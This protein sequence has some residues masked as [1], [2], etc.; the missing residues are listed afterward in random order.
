[1]DRN[2][3]TEDNYLPCSR[4]ENYEPETD[5]FVKFDDHG[6]GQWY[7]AVYAQGK[8]L[9]RSEGYTNEP[10]RDNGVESVKS[11]M[12]SDNNYQAL[13]QSD[14]KWILS[15]R[16][17]NHK[18]I[19]RSC[20]F[21]SEAEVLA[22]L[23][24]ARRAALKNSDNRHEDDYLGCKE[25][26]GK[27][28]STVHPSFGA[29][30][31]EGH[32]FFVQYDQDGKVFLR[33]ERY[34]TPTARDNGINS[35]ISHMEDDKN[36][37][38]EEK[39]DHYFLVLKASNHQEIARSCPYESR[40]IALAMLPSA[41][42]AQ[43]MEPRHRT[44]DYLTCSEYEGHQQSATHPEVVQ[45]EKDGNYYFGFIDKNEG[46]VLMRSE[47]YSTPEACEKGINSVIQNKSIK[48]RFEVE[49]HAG[50]YFLILHAANN[51][52]IARS[53]PL[54]SEAAALALIGLMAGAP[55]EAKEEEIAESGGAGFKWWI[56]ALLL[57]V[58]LFF[59]W[60]SCTS[61]QD[62]PYLS[63]ENCAWHPILFDFDSE[64]IN[65]EAL[66]ELKKVAE[67][68]NKNPGYRAL[69]IGFSDSKGSIEYNRELSM[70]RAVATQQEIAS[71]GVDPT[72]I[73][74]NELDVH[75]PVASNRE[76]AGRRFNRRVV[77]YVLNADHKLV[78]K[79]VELEIPKQLQ[80][81]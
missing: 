12:D 50:H 4:Y 59:L 43:S 10:A 27:E 14:G 51:Q 23:P 9:L 68:M 55:T 42:A 5:G 15:L 81:N 18:E 38:I 65:Q 1:M 48:E 47:G 70:R 44:D 25:Y 63:E 7:F 69:L 24:S 66:T 33:S 58:I 78:C 2:Q 39:F 41:V 71:L 32:Y 28:P 11:N 45:F 79:Q 37:Q 36:Y 56:L 16:A 61:D 62:T 3:F 74:T 19:A 8:V 13:K 20:R 60:R 22:L 77:I 6:S 76:E 52:E 67:V 49:E 29:F 72:R 54:E 75:N 31:H 17:A 80:T 57:V 30:E 26:E 53:C 40:E 21:D 46:E 34:T 35:V 73:S 64:K